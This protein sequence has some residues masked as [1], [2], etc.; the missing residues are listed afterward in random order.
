[1]SV[2]NSINSL[3]NS[4]ITTQDTL[5]KLQMQSDL[6]TK[7]SELSDCLR[8]LSRLKAQPVREA[9]AAL[10]YHDQVRLFQRLVNRSQVGAVLLHGDLNFGHDLL[11]RRILKNVPDFD[12]VEPV[13]ISCG[14]YAVRKDSALLI[15]QQIGRSFGVSSTSISVTSKVVDYVANAFKTRSVFILLQHVHCLD[16]QILHEM[17]SEFW[18]PLV[19]VALEICQDDTDR[20]NFLYLFLTNHRPLQD[21]TSALWTD[22]LGTGWRP[23]QAVRMPVLSRFTPQTIC[24]WIN[25]Y[26]D[27]LPGLA[28]TDPEQVSQEIISETDSG[29]PERVFERLGNLCGIDFW[30]G[31]KSWT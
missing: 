28:N 21:N 6:E 20:R 24:E 12:N 14:A 1:M 7:E 26:V 13:S 15:I 5:R 2:Q 16:D 19:R 23:E 10:D 22:D 17:L 11:L 25:N 3:R 4:V 31:S 8:R 27:H 30:E 18:H 9:I 29:V